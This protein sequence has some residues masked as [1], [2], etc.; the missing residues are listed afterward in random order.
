MLM[1]AEAQMEHV[2]KMG[3]MVL[4]VQMAQRA[5]KV[6]LL[7][8]L[9]GME[10]MAVPAKLVLLESEEEMAVQAV[11]CWCNLMAMQVPL[12][13]QEYATLLLTLEAIKQKRFCL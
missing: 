10:K 2:L 12:R 5:P 11:M 8:L 1:V 3:M 4:K 6:C 9:E 7:A 13:S